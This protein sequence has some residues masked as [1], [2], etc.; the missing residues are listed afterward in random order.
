MLYNMSISALVSVH[1]Q[2]FHQ[3]AAVLIQYQSGRTKRR[4]HM[5]I[6]FSLMSPRSHLNFKK[7]VTG[8]L[9]IPRICSARLEQ[10]PIFAYASQ[11]SSHA[12]VTHWELT[13]SRLPTCTRVWVCATSWDITS[14]AMKWVFHTPNKNI[15]LRTS[16]SEFSR[17]APIPQW[18]VKAVD[19]L[20]LFETVLGNTVW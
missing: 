20:L 15:N 6:F 14:M 2:K 5:V 16:I 17:N 9:Y 7:V 12:A 4:Y 13:L 11:R 1:Q 18:F 10:S 19:Q 3:E 8:T